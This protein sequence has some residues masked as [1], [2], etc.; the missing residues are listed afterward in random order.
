MYRWIQPGLSAFVL[1]GWLWTP[2][3]ATAA[4]AEIGVQLSATQKTWVA[5]QVSVGLYDAKGKTLATCA[6]GK[7]VDVVKGWIQFT[8]VLSASADPGEVIWVE[9]VSKEVSE[10][11]KADHWGEGLSELLSHTGQPSGFLSV[12]LDDAGLQDIDLGNEE[13]DF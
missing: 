7:T 5:D 11:L 6:S 3:L 4:Q 12:D 9:L 8:C 13:P 10:V 2:S 1:L